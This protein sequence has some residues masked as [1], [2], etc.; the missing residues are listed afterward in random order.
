MSH[1]FA[2]RR[3][4]NSVSLQLHAGEVIA[5]MGP[6]GS[7]KSTLLHLL[8][9]LD[10]P[11]QGEVW[12]A[13]QCVSSLGTQQRSM[14]RAR[15][16]GLVFQHHYLLEDLTVLQNVLVPLF[17]ANQHD[18]TQQ[19]NKR[20]GDDMQH[21]F[22]LL[23]RVGLTQRAQDYP[24]VLSGGERQRV[25]LV[26]ALAVQPLMVLADEPTGSLDYANS[27][28]VTTLLLELSRAQGAG[29]LLVTHDDRVAT[30]A[31][32]TI[33]LLDGTLHSEKH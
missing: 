33:S 9:G 2:Q 4:L 32:R 31:D 15:E 12:W 11:Q 1:A 8:A 19:R 24:Q 10:Q 13:G 26:R 18:A 25:A 17:I 3:V 21:V 27:E 23:E 7:G 30:Q 6:S 20:N 5:V 16:V 14:L 28:M 29:V 22:E